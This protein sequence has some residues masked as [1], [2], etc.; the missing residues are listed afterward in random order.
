ML[1]FH[2]LLIKDS[3]DHG[4]IKSHL[5]NLPTFS[6]RHDLPRSDI[7]LPDNDSL[8]VLVADRDQVAGFVDG[9][10]ARRPAAR[11][12]ELDQFQGAVFLDGERGDRVGRSGAEDGRV[13]ER[14]IAVRDDDESL[15]GLMELLAS[16]LVGR[17]DVFQNDKAS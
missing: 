12:G 7:A 3:R 17:C 15:V 5:P 2:D 11:R 13:L 14:H 1:G 10:L 9:E 4:A 8:V 6:F 16:S